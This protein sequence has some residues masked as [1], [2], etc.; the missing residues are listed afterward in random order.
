MDLTTRQNGVPQSLLE[1]VA[2]STSAKQ[3]ASH[4][5]RSHQQQSFVS[6][7]IL[8]LELNTPSQIQPH[9]DLSL[10]LDFEH[11]KSCAASQHRAQ[12]RLF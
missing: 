10:A 7:R 4:V 5:S 6:A 11:R 8:P 1:R 2:E 12:Q 9:P 3:R